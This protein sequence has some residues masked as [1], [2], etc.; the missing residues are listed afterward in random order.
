MGL[1][2]QLK[3]EHLKKRPRREW[4]NNQDTE[5]DICAK[6]E[7]IISLNNAFI[8]FIFFFKYKVNRCNNVAYSKQI[9]V[10]ITNVVQFRTNKIRLTLVEIFTFTHTHKFSTH[11]LIQSAVG[12]C[13]PLYS[14]HSIHVLWTR[15]WNTITT[16][17]LS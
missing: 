3:H 1:S 17:C 13:F 14:L 4:I 12:T 7:S 15:V 10:I 5:T 9:R 6:A 2:W 8:Q 11:M 16:P